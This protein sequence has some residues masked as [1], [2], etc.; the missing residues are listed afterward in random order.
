MKSELTDKEISQLCMYMRVIDLMGKNQKILSDNEEIKK[1]YDKLCLT[2]SEIM[3]N[4][5][6]EQRDEV[7]EVHKIQLEEI[8]KLE[9][10]KTIQKTTQKT[11]H[12]EIDN[13]G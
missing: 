9:V 12:K 4:I 6:D 2:V 3:E 8:A 1:N 7:L 10:K 13:D 11:N 5:S